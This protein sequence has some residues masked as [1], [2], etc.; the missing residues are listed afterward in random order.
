MPPALRRR[1]E[2][3]VGAFETTTMRTQTHS[4]VLVRRSSLR[5]HR[6]GRRGAAVVELA[7]TAPILFLLC[8]GMID[9]GRA[10]MVQ[11]LITNAA[12]DG[13]RTAVLDGAT[14]AAIEAQVEAYLSSSTIPDAVVTVAPNPLNLANL[15]D[16]VSVTVE[17]PFDSVSWLPSSMYF[18]GANLQATVVMRR[19][20]SNGAD[21]EEEEEE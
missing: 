4:S 16:P 8:F 5:R 19:E 13:A 2:V 11:N 15:G 17:V 9:V 20:V 1:V 14:A 3:P 18:Q 7:F 12:R 21:T 10:V 6:R